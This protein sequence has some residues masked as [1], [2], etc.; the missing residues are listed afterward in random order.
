MTEVFVD[1]IE[2]VTEHELVVVIAENLASAY[3]N[4]PKVNMKTFTKRE[5]IADLL[6]WI[7]MYDIEKFT[8]Y[9]SNEKGETK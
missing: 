6:E 8:I 2:E 7:K 1:K 3:N 4:K 5:T 9:L